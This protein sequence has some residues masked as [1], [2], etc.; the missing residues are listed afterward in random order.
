[1][2]AI[3]KKKEYRKIGDSN[4]YHDAPAQKTGFPLAG[5][6]E[7]VV[8]AD[9]DKRL[10]ESAPFYA[11][12]GDDILIA[13]KDEDE[14]KRLKELV[15]SS[16]EKKGL[17]LSAAKSH[18]LKPGETCEYLGL[19]IANGEIDIAKKDIIDIQNDLSQL[20]KRLI[21]LFKK[22]GIPTLFRLRPTLKYVQKKVEQVALGKY[23]SCI[24]T[25]RSLHQ[26]DEAIVDA[27][28]TIVT[29]K[30]GKGRYRLTYQDLQRYGYRSLVNRYYD[31]I[32][33]K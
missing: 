9:L 17:S 12:F 28:R 27:L 10:E 4:L 15:V 2:L 30:E 16:L 23:F 7:N 24:S 31:Y 29:G 13:S 21:I 32:K 1:M 19:E 33:A 22:Q 20:K 3:A 18:L 14:I 11:R 8:L 25:S 5:L 26:I 6:M